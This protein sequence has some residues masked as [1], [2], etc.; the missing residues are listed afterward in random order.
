MKTHINLLAL[1][2][3]WGG[4]VSWGV[5]TVFAQPLLSTPLGWPTLPAGGK[6]FV[7]A[8]KYASNAFVFRELFLLSKL[9]S[10]HLLLFP[11]LPVKLALKLIID[12]ILPSDKLA[13]CCHGIAEGFKKEW[14]FAWNQYLATN[15]ESEKITLLMAMSCARSPS[16]LSQ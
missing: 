5:Q 10:H 13:V 6:N 9:Q 11:K 12:R 8:H 14:I 4:T 15:V 3:S 7:M 1:P 16:L 2:R